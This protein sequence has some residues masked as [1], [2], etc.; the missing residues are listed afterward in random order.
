MRATQNRQR[1]QT[2]ERGGQG[3][4]T[5]EGDTVRSDQ[6]E[7]KADTERQLELELDEDQNLN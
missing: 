1:R 5:E 6:E 2:E 4:I 7:E 3:A